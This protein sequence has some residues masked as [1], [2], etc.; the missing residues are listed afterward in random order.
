LKSAIESPRKGLSKGSLADAGDAFDQE[1]AA[2][3]QGDYRQADNVILAPDH[4]PQGVFQLRRT[5]GNGGGG[6]RGHY[7]DSTMRMGDAA[8]TEVMKSTQ[9]SALSAQQF[10]SLAAS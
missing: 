9:Q 8:V 1:V 10:S 2:S 7:L 4:F 6:F 3:H 5:R